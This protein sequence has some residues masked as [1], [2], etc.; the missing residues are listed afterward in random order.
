MRQIY[1]GLLGVLGVFSRYYVGLSVARVIHPPFPYGTFLINITGAFVVGIVYVLGAEH[2]V[3]SEDLRIGVTVGFL[4]GYT[5]FSSYCLE[6]VRLIEESEYLS[7]ALYAVL[8]TALGFGGAF[9]GIYV[10]RRLLSGG[11]S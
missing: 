3:L 8:S 5:T 1:I 9:V 11:A 4:G 6:F 2:A 7:A 10:T